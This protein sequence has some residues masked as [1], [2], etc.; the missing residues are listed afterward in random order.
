MTLAP[1]L[2][3]PATQDTAAAAASDWRQ[4]VA[5]AFSR[6][7]SRYGE[8]ATA[9]QAMGQALWQRL[10]EHATHILDLGCGPGHWTARLAD[11]YSTSH[12]TPRVVGLDLA[13]GMLA[14]AR[15]Q[16]GDRLDWLCGDAAHLPLADQSLDLVFSNL[17][18]QWCPDT[19]A[20]L[21]ELNR[22]LRPGGRALINM[23]GPGTLAEVG[24]AWSRP[25]ALLR[26]HSLE[27]LEQAA[28][29][30]G[31]VEADLEQVD[32][33][34]HYPDLPAVMASIK[35]VGAQLSRPTSPLTRGDVTRARERYEQLRT[36]DGLPVTYQRLTLDLRKT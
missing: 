4:R 16:H 7:A 26:F 32:A 6:A 5:H 30:A 9:Q 35:G 1:P 36:S 14:T 24:W 13:P 29:R 31:F 17:A 2:S 11:H 20:V 18:I 12:S 19:D 22:V 33:R 15:S 25:A 27:T 3:R 21:A 28:H 10:P 34:F 8:L 23:L